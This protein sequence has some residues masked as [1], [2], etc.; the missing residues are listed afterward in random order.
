[1]EGGAFVH[2][3]A[4]PYIDQSPEALR[5]TIIEGELDRTQF[6]LLSEQ[7]CEL[8]G[9]A[10]SA[11]VIG[12]SHVVTY[13]TGAFKLHEI[14]AC[15][16]LEDGSYWS[17]D[18]LTRTQITY[19]Y[20]DYRYEFHIEKIPWDDHEPATIAELERKAAMLRAT[21]GIGLVVD[22]PR[23][24]LD[25]TPKTIVLGQASEDGREVIFTTAHSYPNVRGLVISHST[26]Q[27]T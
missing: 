26:L 5:L 9:V 22:F 16:S 11:A 3:D 13:D 24:D 21:N 27:Y 6:H 14:F 17:F 25:I 18:T 7:D 10:V 2:S 4:T 8:A 15:V 1:M 12:A 20:P 23:G 19:K